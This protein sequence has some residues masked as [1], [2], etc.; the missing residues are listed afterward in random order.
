LNSADVPNFIPNEKFRAGLEAMGIPLSI[1]KVTLRGLDEF[2]RAEFLVDKTTKSFWVAEVEW[3]EASS[4]FA[5][6][7]CTKKVLIPLSPTE[8]VT[9]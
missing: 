1:N 2:E 9:A 5:W 6:S 8:G 7:T 3:V 4:I